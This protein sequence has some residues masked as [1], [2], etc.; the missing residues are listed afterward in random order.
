[1]C[2]WWAV[3]EFVSATR[4]SNSMWMVFTYSRLFVCLFRVWFSN[5]SNLFVR[6]PLVSIYFCVC[7]TVYV[8]VQSIYVSMVVFVF[9]VRAGELSWQMLI[10]HKHIDLK[11][12]FN[13]PLWEYD[14][15]TEFMKRHMIWWLFWSPLR[16]PSQISLEQLSQ[17]CLPNSTHPVGSSIGASSYINTLLGSPTP[18]SLFSARCLPTLHTISFW[19]SFGDRQLSLAESSPVEERLWL[20]YSA[21]RFRA[22]SS[23][24]GMPSPN[25]IAVILTLF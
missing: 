16:T 12:P 20:T 14:Q 11:N 19:H 3:D 6:Q 21:D 9:A 13:S 7:M 23:Q 18:P 1:M 5:C 24:L 22:S 15:W 25:N 2:Q 17:L 10:V 8:C 4:G